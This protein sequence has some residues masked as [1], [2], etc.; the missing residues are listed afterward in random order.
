MKIIKRF[1]YLL[2]IILFAT[3]SLIGCQTKYPVDGKDVLKYIAD[4]RFQFIRGYDENDKP[5][6]L[7]Y[8][9]ADTNQET[10]CIESRVYDY[11]ITSDIGYIVG[12]KG[13]TK[14]DGKTGDIKQSLD[15]NDFN[16]ED[17]KNFKK[18]DST[19]K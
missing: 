17:I 8:D 13:Y 2:F 3:S 19:T 5:Y 6:T 4:G 1:L 9:Q 14:V 15:I 18:L 12:K 10:S 7:L 11:K 16:D